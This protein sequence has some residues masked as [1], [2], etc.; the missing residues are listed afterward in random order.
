M[1]EQ[2]AAV[3][4]LLFCN[5]PGEI[6]F[7]YRELFWMLYEGRPQTYAYVHTFQ[8]LHISLFL[9]PERVFPNSNNVFFSQQ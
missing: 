4:F 8:K 6:T 2:D 1:V 9:I 3:I 5:Q 7:L